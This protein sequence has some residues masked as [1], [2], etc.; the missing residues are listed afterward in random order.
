MSAVLA[1][2]PAKM[3]IANLQTGFQILSRLP[4]ANSQQA[5]ME[6]NQ[7]LDS[8]LLAPPDGDVY[9][10]LLEQTRISLCFIEDELARRYTNKALPLGEV[11]E[12]IFRQVVATW[13]KA[14]RAY[15]HCAQLPHDE[16]GRSEAERLALILHRCIYYTG[17]AMVEHHRARQEFP[18]GLWLDLHGYYA[19]AEEWG[20]ATLYVPDSLDSLG[21]GT[22]CM[23]A[24]VSLLLCEL[25]GP[26]SLSVRE[27]DLVRRWAGNWS[28]LVSVHPAVPDDILPEFV[29]DLM[30]DCGLRAAGDCPQTDHLRRLDS[31][32]LTAQLN[33]VRI[34]LQRRIPPAQLGLGEDCTAAQCQRLLA[35]LFK[36]WSMLRATRKFRRHAAT[37][38]SKMCSGFAAIH[39]YISGKEFSQPESE[40]AYSRD[41]FDSLFAFRH[42]LE[43]MQHLETR[44]TQL[45]FGL[46]IWEVVDQ[47]A[48]GFRLLRS[49]AGKRIE[50][51]Q[52]LSIYPHDG[53]SQLLAQAVWL[54]QERGGS[55]V[56]GI[57][58]LPGRPQAVAVRPLPQMGAPAEP[59]GRAFLL[60]S[61]PAIGA[62]QTLV[63]ARGCYHPE[64]VLDLYADGLSRVRLQRLIGSGADFERVTFVAD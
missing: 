55:L 19:S 2:V 14:A 23:A 47:C 54:M 27:L 45:G 4:L 6:I 8:L 24:F 30:Q 41:E 62:E 53:S 52:L 63:V 13:L 3:K 12:E 56:A 39:Y 16:D 10:Q 17:M 7:F 32:R 57:A 9:L 50:P 29:V 37:G 42:M 18:A 35:R 46:D 34:Q 43:P 22:H 33:Q 21:R 40:R 5:A 49:T 38:I 1:K 51:G 11:E 28:P 64:R 36:P 26:Y 15:A 58:A 60:P 44:Q 31:S 59:F 20:V 25:A 61:V 48:N